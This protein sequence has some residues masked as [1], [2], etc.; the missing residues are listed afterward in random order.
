[1]P[2]N[3]WVDSF[4]DGI[5]TFVAWLSVGMKQTMESYCDLQTADSDQVL[6]AHDGSLISV[7]ALEGVNTLIGQEEFERIHDI[8]LR[9]L[10]SSM[11][12]AGH[13]L[14]VYFSYAPDRIGEKLSHH[15]NASRQTIKHLSL[16]LA[17][18][19]DEREKHLSGYCAHEDVYLVLWT[20]VS[21]LTSKEQNMAMSDKVKAMK[22]TKYPVIRNAQNIM[23]GFPELRDAHDSFVRA[24]YQDICGAGVGSN[25][26]NAHEAIQRVRESIDY[27]FTDRAWKPVLPGDKYRPKIGKYFRGDVGEI[28]WPSLARQLFPRDAENLDLRT[29]KIGDLVYSSV[30]IDLFP[31]EIR[32]FSL[33]FNR[34]LQNKM[35][36]RISFTVDGGG[37]NSLKIKRVMSTLL[38][39][40]SAQNR[41]INDAVELL[42]YIELN[43]DDAVVK[44][45]V[46]AATWAPQDQMKLLRTRTAQLVRAMQGWGSCDVAQTCGDAFEGAVSSMLAVTQ[47][48]AATATVASLSDVLYMMPFYRPSSPWKQGA[49]L[50][51]SPDGKI[52]PYQPGSS[53]QTTW[54]DLIYARPGSG[55]S[56]LSNAINLAL[57]LAP[58]QKRLPRISIIDIGPS[59]SGLISLLE[60][61]L[62][63]DQKHL[64]A[65]HRLQMD[66]RHSIN[67]FDTQLGCR[68]PM[69]QERSFLVNFILL[70]LT[71]AGESQSYDGI[72]DMIG[73][74]VDELYK[75]SSDSENPSTYQSGIEE[76]IDALLEEINF[77]SDS[78]T[79][80]WEVTD[81][82]FGAGFIH[83]ALLAQRHAV[84]RL[85]DLTAVVRTPAVEDLYGKI[86][87]STGETIIDAF[88]RMI[89]SAIREYPILGGVTQFDIGDA[90]IISLDLDEVAKGGGPAADRQTAV[91]YML[92]RHVLGKGFYFNESNL[93]H[94]P[95]GYRNYH[96][97]RIH[98]TREDPK[99]LVFDEFHRTSK[100]KA[101]RDQLLIDMREGRKWNVQVA[102]VSQSLDDFDKEMVNFG[103]SVFIMDAGPEQAIKKT[104]AT[105][106]LSKTAQAALR[107]HVRG[108]RDGGA[109]FLGQFAMKSG[110]QIQLLT[111]TLGPMEL[112]AFSSSAMDAML[113]NQLYKTIGPVESRRVLSRLFPGGSAMRYIER[114]LNQIKEDT[115]IID[116]EAKK[117]TLKELYELIVKEY[118]VN[119][120]FT[121]LPN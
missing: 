8:L 1:M 107:N 9:S 4:L 72:N 27:E 31:K 60:E 73:M 46:S 78:K 22:E 69:P 65:Y 15:V 45:R 68:F 64:V 35:P 94:V 18:L 16:D 109:T 75:S 67:P 33:L 52:S 87:I 115:G 5:D 97:K 76:M 14:Q 74:L 6:V 51:R 95:E 91:M 106:G 25:I 55:K 61:A 92:A 120:N 23:A 37:M 111:L 40:S 13:S 85:G 41:L 34:V 36:W 70:L 26:L 83:E 114:K 79:T 81:A 53:L 29:C 63:L 7:I 2:I 47:N 105:F 108:P 54:I 89:S 59:S 43:T 11:G 17:D 28:M 62:P 12:Y 42:D 30:F 116:D 10:Q 71:P 118:K 96:E 112:W 24:V 66:K 21:L 110:N 38:S 113:R 56:V 100:S 77:I 117:S 57:C 19:L 104:S 88:N 3:K 84:P 103:T 48:N 86:K 50:F 121:I 82:L 119:P 90:R 93:V 58:S 44:L 99:R 32:A 49:L 101:V 98:E 20:K 102:L 80:W 39:F